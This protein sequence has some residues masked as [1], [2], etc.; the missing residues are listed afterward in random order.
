MGGLIIVRGGEERK[1]VGVEKAVAG[2]ELPRTA[3]KLKLFIEKSE[4]RH[5]DVN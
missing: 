4:T 1:P 3:S 5:Q 2:T